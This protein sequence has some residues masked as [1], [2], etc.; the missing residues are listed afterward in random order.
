MTQLAQTNNPIATKNTKGR[1]MF[2]I[3]N[4][5]PI[6]AAVS[7]P[8]KSYFTGNRFAALISARETLYARRL[9][10]CF[11]WQLDCW[12]VPVPLVAASPC[13]ALRGA[14]KIIPSLVAASLRWIL[15]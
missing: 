15:W 6:G 13:C 9:F 2:A 5:A 4:R 10:L 3:I 1:C 8:A 14:L 11:L 12:F 7:L